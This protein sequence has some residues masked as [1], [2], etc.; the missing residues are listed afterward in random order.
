MVCPHGVVLKIYTLSDP[1]NLLDRICS[2]D[3]IRVVDY[4]S[5]QYKIPPKKDE[6]LESLSVAVSMRGTTGV[7]ESLRVVQLLDEL[8][9]L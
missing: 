7:D 1:Q 2:L 5:L 9:K 8:G 3:T 6:I 4:P